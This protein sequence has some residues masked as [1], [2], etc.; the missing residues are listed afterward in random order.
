[1]AFGG[2]DDEQRDTPTR[3]GSDL[4]RKRNKNGQKMNNERA[5]FS[6]P[7]RPRAQSTLH[8][9]TCM[10]TTLIIQYGKELFLSF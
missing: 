5:T 8:P 1:M 7:E 3:A 6:S 4:L 10:Q 9:R 2:G